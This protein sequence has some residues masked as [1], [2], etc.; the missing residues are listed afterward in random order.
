MK[1]LSYAQT[2]D[3]SVDINLSPLIDMMFLLLIFFIV[4]ASFVDEIG[5]EINRPKASI[6]TN[7]EKKSIMIGIDGEGNVIYN[8]EQIELN[9]LR[10]LVA[11]ML[12]G[13]SKPVVIIADNH[14]LTGV[15][16]DVIDECKAAGANHV[17]LATEA[18]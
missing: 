10:A 3:E 7:L 2:M 11:N 18:D 16:V 8:G 6:T 1:K 4:T 5:V 9:A 14:S 17:S 13:Q 12:R 15:L